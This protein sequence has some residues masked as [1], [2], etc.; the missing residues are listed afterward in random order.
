MVEAIPP[1]PL[2]AA[3]LPVATWP[4]RGPALAKGAAV[5][6]HGWDV[7]SP[8]RRRPPPAGLAAVMAAAAGAAASAAVR[9]GRW[10]RH[11]HCRPRAATAAGAIRRNQAVADRRGG[12][13][14]WRDDA[15]SAMEP[16]PRRSRGDLSGGRGGAD[17]VPGN[18]AIATGG[19]LRH[20]I[21]LLMQKLNVDEGPATQIA[22]DLQEFA[23]SRDGEDPTG[24]KTKRWARRLVRGLSK[25]PGVKSV[26]YGGPDG[27]IKAIKELEKR[28]DRHGDRVAAIEAQHRAVREG[29]EGDLDSYSEATAYM[30]DQWWVRSAHSRV[31]QWMDEYFLLTPEQLQRGH[32]PWAFKKSGGLPEGWKRYEVGGRVMF[33]NPKAKKM[34]V[35]EPERG[36]DDAKVPPPP[37]EPPVA[38]LDVGSC[39][40]SFTRFPY[41]VEPTALDLRPS[42]GSEGVLQAD[43]FEV[44][45]LDPAGHAPG[46]RA[47]LSE[48]GRLEGL[49]A[50]SFD[51]VVL[52][53]VLSYIADPQRRIEMIARARRCL[54]DDRGLLFVIEVGSSMADVSWYKGDAAADWSMA[55]E[56]AGFKAMKFEDEVA[57]RRPWRTHD[58]FQWVF[59]TAPVQDAPLE[60]LMTPREMPW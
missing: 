7:A 60:P 17:T 35:K 31:A 39:N 18:W 25:H 56:G 38:L 34:Q 37:R 28:S 1:S 51:V 2:R 44:P 57:E 21:Q 55:I 41:L 59:E 32:H 46:V 26:L 47:L 12:A 8:V 24:S 19:P 27:T 42:E 30:A 45:I 52:S 40:N 23:V 20:S 58:V 36:A 11:R 50:G 10:L 54:R 5:A 4:S 15:S 16:P 9:Q 29:K 48:D 49:V 33:W 13:D 14:N 43:F 53:L 6:E 3:A 22:E